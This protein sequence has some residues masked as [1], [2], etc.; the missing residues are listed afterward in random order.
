[1]ENNKFLHNIAMG[2]ILIGSLI[3]FF[4]AFYWYETNNI[5]MTLGMI[6]MGFVALANFYLH[7]VKMK[8]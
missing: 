1:M 5:F 8:K 4:I 3:L 2:I 7:L 6:I